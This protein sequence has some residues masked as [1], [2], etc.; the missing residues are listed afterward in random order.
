MPRSVC[1]TRAS[2]GAAPPGRP[3]SRRAGAVVL[4]GAA[5]V[6]AFVGTAESPSGTGA[7]PALGPGRGGGAIKLAGAR[8]RVTSVKMV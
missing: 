2:N 4:R 1:D 5:H 8:R 3:P 6:D 7:A